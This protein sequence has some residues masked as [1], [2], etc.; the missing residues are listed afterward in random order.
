M[1]DVVAIARKDKVYI[2]GGANNQQC[3]V[4]NVK[5]ELYSP[6]K[7]HGIPQDAGVYDCAYFEN[8]FGQACA[9]ILGADGV[10][11]HVCDLKKQEWFSNNRAN[12]ADL[13]QEGGNYKLITDVK[14]KSI[15]HIFGSRN[16]GI[17]TLKK[18]ANELIGGL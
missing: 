16:Y 13:M 4:T 18:K 14:N 10:G 11:L 8:Q 15:V 1:K 6:I 9:I 5:D 3:L 17:L 7:G 12:A 2:F